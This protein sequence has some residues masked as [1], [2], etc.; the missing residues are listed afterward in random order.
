MTEE[1]ATGIESTEEPQERSINDLIDLPYSEMTE[2]EIERVIEF[3]SAIKA[4]DENYLKQLEAINERTR[5]L[6][7]IEQQKANAA[8]SNLQERKRLAKLRFQQSGGV[9]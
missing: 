7:A 6:M 2:E 5:A 8:I 3:K 9:I 4:R 1:Q